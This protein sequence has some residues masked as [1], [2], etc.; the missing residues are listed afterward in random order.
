MVTGTPTRTVAGLNGKRDPTRLVAG[1]NSKMDPYPPSGR[2][3]RC[4][5]PPVLPVAVLNG[6]NGPLPSQWHD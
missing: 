4:K 5:G 6:K 1:L 3:K 2:I